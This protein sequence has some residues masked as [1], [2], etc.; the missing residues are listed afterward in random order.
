[1]N[2]DDL[3]QAN[4]KLLKPKEGATGPTP[5]Q[6]PKDEGS[7]YENV[8]QPDISMGSEKSDWKK[9]CF[10]FHLLLSEIGQIFLD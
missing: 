1:M 2:D 6:E 9:N 3:E 10:E 4:K 5:G 7:T 8:Y